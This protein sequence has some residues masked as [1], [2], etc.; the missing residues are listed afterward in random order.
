MSG[1]AKQ[2][3]WFMSN[4]YDYVSFCFW[5]L[6]YPFYSYRKGA[7]V[8]YPE[9]LQ[10]WSWCDLISSDSEV[11]LMRS[12]VYVTILQTEQTHVLRPVTTALCIFTRCWEWEPPQW[13]AGGAGLVTTS[14][15]KQTSKTSFFC[16]SFLLLLWNSLKSHTTALWGLF[17]FFFLLVT[18]TLKHF[19]WQRPS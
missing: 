12:E 4:Q 19:Q 3:L 8:R 7:Q 11:V 13:K 18:H 1:A 9:A 14:S 5:N 15:E 17:F 10:L 2:K 6:C 16:S